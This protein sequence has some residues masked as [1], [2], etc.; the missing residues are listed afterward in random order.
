MWEKKNIKKWD[1]WFYDL[2][3]KLTK[4]VC[5]KNLIKSAYHIFVDVQV[6]SITKDQIKANYFHKEFMEIN[7]KQLTDMS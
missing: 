3:I 6:I 7:W 5:I 4:Y 2:H 1:I